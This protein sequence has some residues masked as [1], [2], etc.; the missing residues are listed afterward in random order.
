M[1]L[2]DSD[3]HAWPSHMGQFLDGYNFRQQILQ[4]EL[5]S[6]AANR[7]NPNLGADASVVP[8]RNASGA[9]TGISVEYGPK[10][11]QAVIDIHNATARDMVKAAGPDGALTRAITGKGFKPGSYGEQ[12]SFE[13]IKHQSLLQHYDQALR[14]PNLSAQDRQTLTVQRASVAHDLEFYRSQLSLI[15]AHPELGRQP[16]INGGRVDVKIR[17]AAELA[18]LKSP[19]ARHYADKVKLSSRAKR[20]NTV[21]DRSVVNIGADM[22]AIRSGQAQQVGDTFIVNG[23]TYG[24]HDGTL[25]P[26]SGPGLYKLDRG[27]YKALGILNE[28]GGDTPEADMKLKEERISIEAKAEALKV[29]KEIHK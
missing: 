16:A 2:V 11:S 14:N 4:A 8:T 22:A 1:Q 10:A 23:R 5:S 9:I 26:I 25:Y 17:T 3:M 13:A 7:L 24:M 28:S 29:F 20:V 19:N 21:I 6:G 12:V 15:D 18:S 27:T